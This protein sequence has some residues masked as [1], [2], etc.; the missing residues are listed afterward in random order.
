M[1]VLAIS[2]VRTQNDL[3][4]KPL[5]PHKFNFEY[6]AQNRGITPER[7]SLLKQLYKDYS[8]NI[9]VLRQKVIEHK[10]SDTEA[11]IIFTYYSA[12]A[13]NAAVTL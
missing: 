5:F 10:L 11:L 1:Y 6:I 7:I 13:N 9:I 4:M 2:V 12:V 3:R 8:H